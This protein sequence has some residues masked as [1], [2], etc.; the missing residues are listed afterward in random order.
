MADA[1]SHVTV[2]RNVFLA[3]LVLTV[4]T[5]AVAGLNVGTGAA[6]G[7]A[8][9]IAA[10][11]GSLVANYFMHLATEKKLIYML[12]V[13]TVAFFLALMIIP[14]TDIMTHVRQ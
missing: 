4:V 1:Q 13:L 10:F 7:I 11:K 8:L 5:V 12:L 2:Y 6:V 9:L 14:L 3:L